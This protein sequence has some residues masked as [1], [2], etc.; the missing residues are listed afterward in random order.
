ME[1]RIRYAQTTDG[2]NIAFWTLGEGLPFV[3]MPAM[4]S[5]VQLEWQYPGVRRWYERLARGGMLVRDDGRG[6]GR[7]GGG[8]WPPGPGEVRSGRNSRLGA[9]GH[10]L[11]HPPAGA[12]IAP[13]PL[14]YLR[15]DL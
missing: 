3:C 9:S 6:G 10:R 1:P 15:K 13:C 12:G 7:S 11:R 2:V 5:H 4:F 14:V 8:G